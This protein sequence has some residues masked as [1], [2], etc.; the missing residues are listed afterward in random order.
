MTR[1]TITKKG[2]ATVETRYFIGSLATDVKETARAIRGHWM[3]ESGM[4]T[5]DN[6]DKR[7]KGRKECAF[8]AVT[9]HTPLA[10]VVR[11]N[12]GSCYIDFCCDLMC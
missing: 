4:A 8:L 1:N 3:V 12:D 10:D 6:A 5:D 2:K 7:K 11:N 9:H